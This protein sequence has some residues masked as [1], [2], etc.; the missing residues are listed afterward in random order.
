MPIVINITM[1]PHDFY[2]LTENNNNKKKKNG[3]GGGKRRTVN[4]LKRE[5]KQ[6]AAIKI[7]ALIFKVRFLRVN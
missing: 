5:H 1:V 7:F 3:G 4:N 2:C 6:L